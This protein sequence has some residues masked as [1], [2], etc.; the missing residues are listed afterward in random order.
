MDIKYLQFLF[1][2]KVLVLFFAFIGYFLNFLIKFTKKSC[3]TVFLELFESIQI[4]I[5]ITLFKKICLK[6]YKFAVVLIYIN[7]IIINY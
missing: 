3:R 7:Y 6:K 4:K 1:L 5:E 2:Q